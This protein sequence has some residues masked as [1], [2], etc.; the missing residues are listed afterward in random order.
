MKKPRYTENQIFKIL[1]RPKTGLRYRKHGM[2][3]AVFY[4]WRAKYG[5]MDVSN[6]TRLREL[7]EENKRFKKSMPALGTDIKFSLALFYAWVR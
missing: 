1:K 2:S 7:E 4:K 6:M 5:G 3:D